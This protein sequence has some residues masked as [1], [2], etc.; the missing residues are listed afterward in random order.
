[1]RRAALVTVISAVL[2]SEKV[3]T[4]HLALEAGD[5][6]VAEVLAELLNLLQLQQVNPEHLDP[7]DHQ[8]VDFLVGGEERL[9]VPLLVVD[10]GLDVQ[11]EGL[12][13]RA[14]GRLSG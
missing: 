5:V 4:L 1:M 2:T 3:L 12:A 6:S 7:T 10:E 13:A 9:L 11:V 14:F 8:I